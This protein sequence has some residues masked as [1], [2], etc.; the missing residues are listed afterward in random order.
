[1][2]ATDSSSKDPNADTQA[3]RVNNKME[4]LMMS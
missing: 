4:A 2:T 3:G 1:M